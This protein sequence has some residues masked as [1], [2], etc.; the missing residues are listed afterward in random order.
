VLQIGS[1]VS[2][3]RKQGRLDASAYLVNG[4]A[5]SDGWV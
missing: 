1:V 5:L 3:W 2:M 4:M